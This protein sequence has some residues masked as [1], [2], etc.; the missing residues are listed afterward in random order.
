MSSVM[1]P[2]RVSYIRQLGTVLERGRATMLVAGHEHFVWDEDVSLPSGG[3]IRQVLV[4]CAAGIY[5]YGPNQAERDRA[6]CD[7]I[8]PHSKQR[9][10]CR[11]PHGGG[12]FELKMNRK[13]SYIEHTRVTFT[14]FDVDGA[15]IDVRPMT[16][17]PDGNA[18]PFYLDQ[19]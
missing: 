1:R 11:M 14:I 18:I 5:N 19:R 10:H 4:G 17:D 6:S 15:S 3:S 12:A 16:L 9:M 2:P 7:W 13:K 8:N